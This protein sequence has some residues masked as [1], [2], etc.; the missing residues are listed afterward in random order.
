MSFDIFRHSHKVMGMILIFISFF[1]IKSVILVK[2]QADS[3]NTQI[4]VLNGIPTI[5]D[6]YVNEKSFTFSN[7]FQSGVIVPVAGGQKIVHISGHIRDTDGGDDISV[8]KL[9]FYKTTNQDTCIV[10]SNNCYEVSGCS[11]RADTGGDKDVLEYDCLVNLDYWA[12]STSAGGVTPSAQWIARVVA[13]DDV[14]GTGAAYSVTQEVGT[15]LALTLPS[16]INYGTLLKGQKTDSDNNQELLIVQRGNDVADVE[17]SGSAM[18]CSG[19]GSIPIANQEWAL[20]DI[21]SG[22]GTDL[23][24]L[25]VDTDLDVQ[26]KTSM[27]VTRYLFWNIE[28]PL[29]GLSGSCIGT[30]TI[31]AISAD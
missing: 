13:T 11:V 10:D 23:T 22:S 12:D 20:S 29:E 17:V 18:T 24:S 5:L 1:L 21:D 8:V 15:L 4:Y 6:V 26:Y 16:N 2:T 9:K 14:G 3:V 28:I 19:G 31:T 7:G 27:D 30:N 25:A